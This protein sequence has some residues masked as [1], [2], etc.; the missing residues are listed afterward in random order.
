MKT[1]YTTLFIILIVALSIQIGCKKE[2]NNPDKLKYVWAVGNYDTTTN[3]ALIYFSDNGGENW[4][5]QG[6]GQ[7]ALKDININDVWA[8]DENTVW[9]VADQN[10]ILKT[11]DGGTTWN[12]VTAPSKQNNVELSS[13][14][15]IGSDNIW[16]SGLSGEVYHS[17]D[18]G[19]SWTTIQSEVINN[20][21]M[22]GIHAI[23]SNV[24]YVAGENNSGGFIAMTNDG[25]ITWDSI[26]PANNYN[27]HNWIGVTSSNPSNIVI[28]GQRSH[29]IHS[30]DGGQN[31]TNDSLTGATN[32]GDINCLK[33]LDANTWWGAFDYEG[34][35]ITDNTGNSWNQQNSVPPSGMYL[36][37]IDSYDYKLCVIV[38]S[39]SDS[40]IGKIIKTSDGGQLWELCIETD[41]WMNKVSFIK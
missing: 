26:V 10:V 30:N 27:K 17:T 12:R 3:H 19:N 11:M 35:F 21:S 40:F 4:V 16:I 28:Y 41:A 2:D 33:I 24:V 31:W 20:N 34:I 14:S 36:V 13:I 25:G 5:R 39:S 23:N 29:Y 38:G 1:H 9:A 8:V 18:A 6:E 32:G 22:Q 37:G 15:L 7:A